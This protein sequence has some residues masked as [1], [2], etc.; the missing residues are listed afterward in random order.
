MRAPGSGAFS[1]DRAAVRFDDR[2]YDSNPMPFF[3]FRGK[4][5]IENFIAIL[6]VHSKITHAY[7]GH[8][9]LWNGY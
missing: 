3:L 2:S 8:I 9:S 5:V 7:F 6:A 4:E 1:R